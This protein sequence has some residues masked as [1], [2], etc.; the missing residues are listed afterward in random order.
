MGLQHFDVY[1]GRGAVPV[2]V[3]SDHNPLIFPPFFE[4]HLMPWASFLQP[5]NLQIQHIQGMDNVMADVYTDLI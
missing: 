3:Y 4:K 2:T 5:Y 1:L